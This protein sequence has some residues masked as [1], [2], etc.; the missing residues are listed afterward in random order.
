MITGAYEELATGFDRPCVCDRG[1]R[2]V[3]RSAP[4]EKCHAAPW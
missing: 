2:R 3:Y 4:S 1:P